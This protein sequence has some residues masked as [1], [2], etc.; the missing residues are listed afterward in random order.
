[1]KIK[2]IWNKLFRVRSGL[3]IVVMVAIFI[4]FAGAIQYYFTH[5]AISKEVRNLAQKELEVIDATVQGHL[6]EVEMAVKAMALRVEG[7]LD[8]PESINEILKDM[9]AAC[10]SIVNCA[11][12]FIP[13]YY[14]EHGRW[15]EPLAT[16]NDDGSIDIIQAGGPEHDYFELPFYKTT[17]ACDSD[18]WS[19][20]Y[21][22]TAGHQMMV[23]SYSKVI[24]DKQSKTV[25]LLCADVPLDWLEQIANSRHIYPSSYIM[26]LSREGRLIVY[27]VDK[28]KL[29]NQRVHEIHDGRHKTADEMN[30]RMMA[31]ESG[32]MEVITPKG[33]KRLVY[34]APVGSD[35]G[36]SI[37]VICNK[38]E[39]YSDLRNLQLLILLIALLGMASMA[40][41]IWRLARNQL[42]LQE[43]NAANERIS[44][45]LRVASNIQQGMLP[46]TYPPFPLRKDI[47]IYASLTPAKEVGGDLYDYYIRDEKLYFCIGDVSGK[48]VPA[49]LVMA[50][51]RSLFHS[52]TAHESR[53]A[54]VVSIMNRTGC[55]SNE[56]LMFVTCFLGILDL[57]TGRLRYCNAGHDAP[58][59][60]N[61]D[62]SVLLDVV[63]NF[64]LGIDE[65]FQ[66]I[67]QEI[68][69]EPGTTLFLYTDG[70]TEA[71][72]INNKQFTSKRMTDVIEKARQMHK[73]GA[74]QLVEQ[75][76][77]AVKD[78]VQ[79]AEPSDDLAMMA[80][81]YKKHT[82]EIKIEKNINL[83]TNINDIPKLTEFI[84]DVSNNL[85]IDA[86][87]A[88]QVRLA[89]EEAVA[90]IMNYA[91]TQSNKGD[92]N[93]AALGYDDQLLVKITDK[94]V[95]FDPTTHMNV[96]INLSA[97]DRPIGGLGIH[98][99][100]QYMDA[101]NYER[102]ENQNV[103]TLFKN[104]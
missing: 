20:P 5:E 88:N 100:R 19:E 2:E 62:K 52:I 90:N 53:P 71:M 22:N 7:H 93:I 104:I 12:T 60:I 47:D 67:A 23:A 26:M 87:T 34:F 84:T 45:E 86:V 29:L 50:V 85:K 44:S 30:Q 28:S 99:V 68:I 36:W 77:T 49:S 83:S 81:H 69:I 63:P 96:D 32:E 11:V 78:F 25:A 92:I 58:V 6:D 4:E 41:I 37:A 98:L 80:I 43:I 61:D 13:N 15:H 55:H 46:K 17:M 94:G 74:T 27:P 24:K 89:V 66:Y 31:G 79:T 82:H 18:Y 48:G 8:S 51:V 3:F 64:P 59:L 75:M 76:S 95:A 40:Y 1:M 39:V 54:Q 14:P 73:T 56:Q 10:P 57:P 42:R 33:D 70:L 21:W 38:K 103:L 97:E 35:V 16:R 72:D 9:L 101:I 102:I 65:S 91:Y